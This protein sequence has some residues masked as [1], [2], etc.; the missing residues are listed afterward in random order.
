MK[1]LLT[2]CSV[3]LLS[4]VALS[5]SVV[6]P[7]ERPDDP[8]VPP[9]TDERERT[10]A[11]RFSSPGF[12]FTQVNIDSFGQNIVGDAANEP[13]IAVDPNDNNRI[14]IG[15]RQFDTITNNFRQ[16]GNGY[17]AD[18][19]ITWNYHEVIE[20]GI[21]RSDPVLDSDS[22]GNIYYNSLTT[23]GPDFVCH[24]FKSVDGGA[25]WDGGTFAH[26]GDKQ[27]M[28]IDKT[29]GI[30]NGN[31]YSNWTV[32][33]SSC[34]PGFFTRSPDDGATY[35]P[36]VVVPGEPYWGTLSVGAD[37]DVFFGG[38]DLNNGNFQVVRSTTAKDPGETVSWDASVNVDLDAQV[39]GN[40][41]NSSPNPG[42]ILGQIWV[43]TD[44]SAGP[45][46][47]NVYLLCSAE[48]DGS[49][50]PLDVMFSRSTDDGLTW[51]APVRVNDDTGNE[52]QWFGTMSVAP[53]GRIDVVWLDTR[54]NP[55]TV[56][57]SLYYSASI[58]GG[59]SWSPNVRLTDEF[60]PHIGWPNQNKMGD[61]YDMVSDNEGAHLAW[62]ATFNGEQDVYYARI[63][64][65]D[66]IPDAP[67]LSEPADGATQQ[68]VGLALIWE[69]ALGATGYHAQLDTDGSFTSPVAED[70]ALTERFMDV[71]GLFTGTIYY[72]R[73]RAW[74]S[75][76]SGPWSEIWSFTT[77]SSPPASPQ[78]VSPPDMASGIPT[79]MTFEW[80]DTT[81]GAAWGL[82]IAT[83]P[84]FLDP[85]F[86]LSGLTSTSEPVSGLAGETLHYWRANTVTSGGTSVWSTPWSFTT[87][88]APPAA[89]SL[90]APPDGFINP[91]TT[92]LFRWNASDGAL[93]YH[94]Q[95]ATD[96]Q[97][98]GLAVNDSALTGTTRI[99]TNLTDGEEYYWRVAAQNNGGKSDWSDVWTVTVLLTGVEE[100]EGLPTE[101]L[102][103][104]NYPNPFNPT[105]VISFEVPRTSHVDVEVFDI[106]GK[107]V[108]I[109][110]SRE[111][112]AGRYNISFDAA[113]LGG[114]VYF[115]RMT[116]ENFT[117]TR[118]LLLV[119]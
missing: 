54:D 15:W 101:F 112:E 80:N 50:D 33:F 88:M 96:D 108:A 90:L 19:G 109:L 13:S 16:A 76:G 6:R 31:V 84:D 53:N 118:K 32:F 87:T 117:A 9:E 61:Y 72:W 68:P 21:F 69:P 4:V 63:L 60:D 37:G 111:Y 40:Q 94:F 34:P 92:V 46:A 51:S 14:V 113:G 48:P 28:A 25:T 10:S 66:F 45:T 27:W 62:A 1:V 79:A 30:G 29:G 58:D 26:G 70:S 102:L 41:G 7:P 85:Q 110:A 23:Q 77:G 49:S 82:Q 35:D 38:A 64:A 74:S 47:G 95:L 98:G 86:N 106:L 42:G 59:V 8:Y 24:V 39:A 43:G 91:S 17:T 78:L 18:G 99:T 44:H 107:H 114:G 57:S 3:M 105:T 97:F 103:G 89:P 56:L 81:A 75:S 104:Q 93:T 55:G 22:D 67:L 73:S 20:P 36:C 115:Y 52:W 119:K 2:L 71:S 100:A 12:F 116:G 83:D 11:Y 65:E 5:Q